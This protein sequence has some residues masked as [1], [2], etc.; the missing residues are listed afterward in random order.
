M[1]N[2]WERN[3]QGFLRTYDRPRIGLSSDEIDRFLE[4]RPLL[5]RPWHDRT[6]WSY[7]IGSAV[8]AVSAVAVAGFTAWLGWT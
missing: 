1:D 6:P 2:D 7:L 8:G 5:E 3:R 4:E